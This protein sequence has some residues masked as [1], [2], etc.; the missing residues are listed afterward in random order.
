[1]ESTRFTILVDLDCPLCRKEAHLLQWLDRRHRRLRLVNIA[2]PS[3]RPEEY[4]RTHSELM[5]EI[6]GV[7]S[8]GE[9]VTGME[10]FRH[11]YRA[12]GLGWILA[13]T[14]WPILRSLSDMMYRWFARHRLTLTGRASACQTGSC[15][16]RP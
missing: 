5:G 16:P 15:H 6:H 9:L 1:M 2:E 3:F 11:A 7:K 8:D 12:V 14:R 10:V 13:P 4:G